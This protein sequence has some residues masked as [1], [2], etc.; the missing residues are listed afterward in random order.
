MTRKQKALHEMAHL[1]KKDNQGWINARKEDWIKL[2]SCEKFE[3]ISAKEKN[4]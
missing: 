3:R 4:Y 2:I 1:W